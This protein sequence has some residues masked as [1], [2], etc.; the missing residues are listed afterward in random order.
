MYR[1]DRRNFT[2]DDEIGPPDESYH[3]GEGF[4]QTIE[5]AL[6]ARKPEGNNANRG[7]GLFV[8]PEL[9]DALRFSCVMTNSKIYKVQGLLDTVVYH[10]GDMNWT[11]VMNRFL[12]SEE[13]L[14]A[15]ADLYWAGN[16]TFKPCWEVL[17]NK[18][19]VVSVLIP[20]ENERKSACYEYSQNGQNVERVN[21]YKNNL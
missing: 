11:E 21:F 16:K 13:T 4:D 8:F 9:S 5:D 12:G 17:V 15:L 6:E 20:N 3:E 2:I 7:N 18:V 14:N 19:E 1:V 10:R